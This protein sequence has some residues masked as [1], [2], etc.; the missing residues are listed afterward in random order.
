MACVAN[1]VNDATTASASYLVQHLRPNAVHPKKKPVA[2]YRVV[3]RL[4]ST[5]KM[6]ETTAVLAGH[7]ASQASGV[8]EGNAFWIARQQRR[9]VVLPMPGLAVV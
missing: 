4:A 2:V 9:S 5:C 3:V 1:R 7:L 6:T 8:Q